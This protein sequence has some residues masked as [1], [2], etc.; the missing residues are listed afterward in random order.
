MTRPIGYV[1]ADVGDLGAE[2]LIELLGRAGYDA[3]EWTMEQVE[4]LEA[5]AELV[6]ICGLA[7]AAGLATPQ[8]MVHQDYVTPD[9]AVWEERVRRSEAAVEAAASSYAARLSELDTKIAATLAPVPDDRRVLVTNHESFG[10]FAARYDVAVVGAVI[11]SLTTSAGASAGDLEELAAL[12]RDSGVPAIF[13]ETTQPTKLADA[14]ADEVG[15][16]V[17]VVELYTESLGEEGSGA[18]TYVE[19]MRTNAGRIAGALASP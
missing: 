7:R 15:G 14:L 3:V 9:P 18:E 5:P 13:A 11:P 10:Y 6:R 4:P 1:T 8:L 16:D 17:Q 12:I 19:M 2:Q